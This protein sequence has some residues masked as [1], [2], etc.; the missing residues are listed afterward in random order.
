[1]A[2]EF[3]VDI[4]T[5]EFTFI[6]DEGDSIM[7]ASDSDLEIMGAISNGH[8]HMQ[9]QK[10]H[11]NGSHKHERHEVTALRREEKQRKKYREI[12]DYL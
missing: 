8:L 12:D 3:N 11:K 1:M 6:D 7:V 10:S 4:R 2:A 5:V 9:G